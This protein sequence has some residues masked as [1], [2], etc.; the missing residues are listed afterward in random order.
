[1]KLSFRVD[2]TG[3]EKSFSLLRWIFLV[4]G[5]LIFLLYYNLNRLVFLGYLMLAFFAVLYMTFTE[6]ALRSR[7]VGYRWYRVYTRAGVIFDLLAYIPLL[8]ITGGAFSPLYPIAYLLVLHAAV[9][10]GLVGAV[11][12]AG[13]SMAGYLLDIA[14]M[15]HGHIPG[16]VHGYLIDFMFLTMTALVGGTIIARERKHMSDK[17]E[18][19]TLAKRD[20]LTGL[21]NHRV[22]QDSLTDAVN[23]GRSFVLAMMDIDHFKEIN[24]RYGHIAGDACLQGIGRL[25]QAVLTSS[26]CSAYRYGGE[27]FVVIYETKDV[28]EAD[29]V[30]SAFHEE[31]AGHTFTCESASF[32]VTMSTGVVRC[33][34]ES[35]TELLQK[36]DRLLYEAKHQGRNRM[37]SDYTGSLHS[38]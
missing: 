34:G 20:Y 3:L 7:K 23:H 29:R 28:K 10:W 32:H 12:M 33:G 4:V 27:E 16:P 35:P 25:L 26:G 36:A 13:C 14:L 5:S 15:T 18:W 2:D 21:E 19:E 22:F 31:L 11:L 9:Y 30:L 8:L 1:M 6:F 38:A 37:I 17:T 24:D